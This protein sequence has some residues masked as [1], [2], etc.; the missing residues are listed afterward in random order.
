MQITQKSMV[1]CLRIL[2][3]GLF[4]SLTSHAFAQDKRT[5][6]GFIS[7]ES[8]GER[9]IGA[10][11]YDTVHR[12]GAVTNEYG[13]YSITVPNEQVVLK[14]A[15]FG[16]NSRWIVVPLAT[17]EVNISLTAVKELEE[18]VISS[19]DANR[20]V[21]STNSGTIELQMDKLEKLPVLLGEKDV[22]KIIQLLP[23]VKSGGEG[24][25]GLYVRGGGPDQ[26]LI[27][28]D[29]VPIYNASHLFGFFSVFNSD[30]LSQVTLVKGGFPARYGGRVSS[31][32]DMRMKEGNSKHYNVEGSIGMISSR[33]LV[34]GPIKKDKTAFAFSARRTYIDVLTI[35]F[36]K[37]ASDNGYGGYYFYDL[38]AKIQH[39]IND[40]HHLYLSSYFGKDRA[41]F[42]FN[43]RY[44]NTN[45][46][47]EEK[48]RSQLY[49]GNAIAAIR[50]NYR[51]GPKIFA[52]TTVTYSQYKFE[53]GFDME[54]K[55]TGGTN[56]T[57]AFGFKYFS[58][59]ND[60]AGKVD[61]TYIPNPKH[62][63]KFGVGDTYHTF[64]PGV[65]SF[66]QSGNNTSGID[67]S[68]GSYYQYAHELF[69]YAENDHIITNRLKINYGAHLS[70]FIV[71]D[72]QYVQ[73]QPRFSGNFMLDEQSSLK[74]AYARTAQNLHLLSN[75]GI[76]LPTDL[77]VPATEKIAPVIADQVSAGYNREFLKQYN[78]VVEVYY[79][80]M[81]NL[82]QYK[83]GA[84][85]LGSNTDWQTKVES[86]QGW[87]YGLELFVEKRKGR[88]SGWAGYTLSWAERQFDNINDGKRFF[89]RYDRRNDFS[90]A[91]TYDI[92]DK[93]DIG[94]VFVY[95]TGNAVTLPTQYYSVA[96]NPV[97][98][99]FGGGSVGYFANVN[100][101][102][103]PAYHRMD[104]GLNRT[105]K[106]KWGESVLSF[107]VYNVYNRR[108]PFYLYTKA[109]DNGNSKLM[110]VSLF[111]II[112][113]IS[114]KFKLD[115]EAIKQN[116]SHE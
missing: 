33:I 43:N 90:L 16:L 113:S 96:S 116:R 112:P 84:G 23:G 28:L 10:T 35:P 87:S 88:F 63:V 20:S 91:L 19:Q 32:L 110:Q 108:N 42:R 92:N 37:M 74:L 21:E 55:E 11:V 54:S 50:W 106:V 72:K 66:S 9:L 61:F 83:E 25:T 15:S 101:Y 77:W 93:W 97:V 56:Q 58:G 75:T 111:P 51:I 52:N 34:E 103:M 78:A 2:F 98:N 4:L 12:L 114:W 59:I 6:S 69:A 95:G 41:Y 36:Q 57:E 38:N 62:N 8:T 47:T 46:V 85:F 39:K 107:S 73:F 70:V 24:S 104:I 109:T 80:K 105:K 1:T 18:V 82:I 30:A 7:D 22:M 65:N 115:F 60:W 94:V 27:L 45:S 49:W 100:D 76:G 67:T 79:K 102:R 64:K 44:E 89:Y 53:V 68:F 3:L 17:A 26:N 13:F 99:A 5:I 81:N 31:V 71:G 86:G 29:G 14:V 40:K 48:S